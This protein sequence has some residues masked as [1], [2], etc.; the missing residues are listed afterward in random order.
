MLGHYYFFDPNYYQINGY[1]LF[2]SLRTSGNRGGVAIYVNDTFSSKQ[3]FHESYFVNNVLESCVL[4]IS[5]PGKQKITLLN[6]YRPP[7]H[8]SFTIQ[9]S[10]KWFLEIF[11]DVL[12]IFCTRGNPLIVSGDFNLNLHELIQNDNG[13]VSDFVDIMASYGFIPVKIR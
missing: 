8:P 2:L 7:Q 13:L 6:C 5:I 9:E 11:P 10:K 3:L 4:E 12:D 1:D